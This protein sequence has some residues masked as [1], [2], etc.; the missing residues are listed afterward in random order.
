[1]RFPDVLLRLRPTGGE[2][3]PRRNALLLVG[4]GQLAALDAST[5][6]LRALRVVA[7]SSAL[8]DGPTLN[9]AGSLLFL[10]QHGRD[11]AQVLVYDSTTLALQGSAA[12]PVD[13]RLG[14]TDPGSGALYAF[15]AN[16][17]NFRIGASDGGARLAVRTD[18]PTDA[19]ALGWHLALGH[20]YVARMRAIEVRSLATGKALAALPLS[21]AWDATT[22]LLS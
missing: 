7:P 16:S 19:F 1:Y 22:P 14:P 11:A 2:L 18:G 10:L 5:G 20:M 21:V 3:D 4:A 15:G 17:A 12:L 6:R 9:N 13:G 8:L